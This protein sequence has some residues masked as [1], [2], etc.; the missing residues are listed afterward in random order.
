MGAI[1]VLVSVGTA[2]AQFQPWQQQLSE[3]YDLGLSEAALFLTGV[4][5][6]EERRA[7][8][9]LVEDLGICVPFCHI[10]SEMSGEEIR[11]LMA[12]F[13]MEMFN[14]HS[15]ADYPLKFSPAEFYGQILLENG[16]L[17]PIDA[18]E[19]EIVGNLCLDLA[20]LE[21]LRWINPAWYEHTLA[22][23]LRWPVLASHVGAIRSP[24]AGNG[25]E[26]TLHALED[27]DYL[28]ALPRHFF[29]KYMAIEL[30]NSASSQLEA[31]RHIE[32][33]ILATK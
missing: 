16:Y 12:K 7:I 25:A 30:F 18:R 13:G 21:V 23:A 29:G 15:L 3:I 9:A 28:H 14:V 6:E 26:H 20:H 24:V 8:Y 4:P 10:R 31:K 17:S 22:V 11:Y 1:T 5:E 27:F 33:K 2:G 19:A 32:E